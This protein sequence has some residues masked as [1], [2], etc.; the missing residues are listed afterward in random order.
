MTAPGADLAQ[1]TDPVAGRR[2]FVAI[3]VAIFVLALLLRLA[4]YFSAQVDVPIRGDIHQY[5]TYA[6]NLYAHGVFSVAAPGQ[7][8]VPDAFRGPGYPLFLA[9]WMW[10]APD[11]RQWYGFAVGAQIVLGAALAPIAIAWARAWMPRGA[12]LVVGLLV[13]LWPHLIV[14]SSTLLSETLFCACLLL[15]L[16]A[17]GRS[18]RHTSGIGWALAAGLVAGYAYLVNPLVA[19]LPLFVGAVAWRAGRRR[20]ATAMLLAYLAVA[21]AWSMRNASHPGMTG[22]WNRAALNLVEGSWPIYHAAYTARNHDPQ[23]YALMRAIEREEDLM[24]AKP[25]EGIRAVFRRMG[26]RPLAYARW[27]FVEKPWLLW[28]WPLGIGARDIY[29][30]E[31]R[32]S[33]FERQGVFRVIEGGLHLA[34]PALFLLAMPFS[35]FVFLLARRYAT[36]ARGPLLLAAASLVYVA[37]I[38]TVLQADPRYAVAYRPLQVAMAVSCLLWL[39]AQWRARRPPSIGSIG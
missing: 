11:V 20:A 21:G 37:A 17:I 38:H 14:F 7:P 8:L 6:W 9:L 32:N 5:V 26:E 18:L 39:L 22:A 34:N 23:A 29:F 12:A 31:T 27:Y 3:S 16:L 35:V 25:V 10:I 4:Y 36:A 33:P 30:L 28:R 15:M 19:F 2:R 24:V 1:D 13:A